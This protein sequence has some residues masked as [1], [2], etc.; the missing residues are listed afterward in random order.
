MAFEYKILTEQE[1]TD[2][3]FQNI[4]DYI[5]MDKAFGEVHWEG[6]S[7]I[8]PNPNASS[9]WGEIASID[10]TTEGLFLSTVL[11]KPE[12]DKLIQSIRTVLG[13]HGFDFA[14]EEE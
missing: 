6:D 10:K 7:I 13:N 11:N 2:A 3:I 14:V 9:P 8:L 12:R 4:F 5:K 1:V